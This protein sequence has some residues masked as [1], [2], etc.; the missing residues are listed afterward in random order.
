MTLI[1]FEKAH[2]TMTPFQAA[3]EGSLIG[4]ALAMPVH[5]YYDTQ[6]LKREYGIVDHYLN[7]KHPHTGSILWRSH[8]EPINERADILRGQ[9]KYWGQKE[10]HYHQFLKAGE[11][12]LNFQLARELHSL[13][14]ADGNYLSEKWAERYIECMLKPDWHH[15]TYVEEYHRAFFNNYAKGMKLRKC[16]VDDKHIGGLAAVPAL[17]AGLEGK[18]LDVVRHAVQEHVSLT[19]K[20][21]EV[22]KAADLLVTLLFAVAEGDSLRTAIAKQGSDWFSTKKAESW[23]SRPDSEIVGGFYSSACYIEDAMPSALYL[24]WKYAGDFRAGIVA[25]TML[26]GDNCHRAAVVGSL[27]AIEECAQSSV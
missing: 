11:N 20:N 5:W 23:Q 12:T 13:V 16:G 9:A 8:F 25:N 26:G 4:D 15:D 6:A 27:L 19:H 22:L 21:S 14:K 1:E 2:A 7:P 18:S 3:Y 17:V 10:I 24:A